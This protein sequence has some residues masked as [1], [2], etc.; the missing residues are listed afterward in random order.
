[1]R[2]RAGKVAAHLQRYQPPTS[3]G[4]QPGGT[5]GGPIAFMFNPQQ[6][7]LT[8]SAN[9]IPHV[10]RGAADVGVAEFSGS[11]P[12][13]LS[14]EIFL[15]TT[16]TH[17]RSV[18]ERVDALLTCCV[19]TKASIAAKAP[20]PPW[21]KFA[22]GQFQTVSFYSYVSQINA[23]Y[24]LFDPDGTPLRATCSLMLN[25][26]SG[27]TRGQNPTSGS[28]TAR[29]VHRLVAGDSLELLAHREYG[30]PTAWRVIAEANDIDDPVRLRTGSQLLLPA[31]DELRTQEGP[32]V[33]R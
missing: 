19:P 4:S 2:S 3:G 16:D 28:R 6:L 26:V 20:S 14:L 5:L 17:S 27:A 32:H 13:T 8:K 22:W 30:D 15:D 21:V 31:P 1:M 10:V 12:R 18:Q 29:R 7:A 11:G 23:T 25:E 33:Q 9:W 24:S